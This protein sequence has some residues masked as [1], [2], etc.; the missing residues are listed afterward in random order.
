MLP[1]LHLPGDFAQ[2]S[3]R[4]AIRARFAE[5][6]YGPIPEPITPSVQC[7]A[8]EATDAQRLVLTMARGDRSMQVDAA[9]WL[10]RGGATQ[11][12]AIVLDF[13]GPVG[14]LTARFPIDQRAVI[15]VPEALGSRTQLEEDMRGATAYRV[16]IRALMDA[17]YAVLVSCYGS[18]APD[19]PQRWRTHGAGTLFPDA[20]GAITLWAWAFHR[21]TDVAVSHLGAREV[22]IAGHSRLGKAALWAG[23]NDDRIDGVFANQSG[24][25]GAAPHAHPAGETAEQLITRFPHWVR[26]RA[27]PDTLDQHLLLALTAPHR[28]YLGQSRDDHWADPEGSLH[29]LQAAAPAWAADKDGRVGHH[30]RSGEHEMLP[31]D[32]AACLNFMGRR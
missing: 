10:P 28:L 26:A 25:F 21:L 8:I 27:R 4:A 19:C 23:C 16:P 12:V 7:E 18:W 15:C 24:C 2:P 9:L 17:G 32:W 11:R 5:E 20:A 6:I 30:M 13:L 31:E 3:V 22:L 29:A 1:E 14:C